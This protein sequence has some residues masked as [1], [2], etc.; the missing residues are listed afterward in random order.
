[1][2]QQHTPGAAAVLF[3]RLT[4]STLTPQSRTSHDSHDKPHL[5]F[6]DLAID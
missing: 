2:P 5:S 6:A 3:R 4:T 1:V